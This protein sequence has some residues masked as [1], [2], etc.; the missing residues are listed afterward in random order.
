MSEFTEILEMLNQLYLE[1]QPKKLRELT[2]ELKEI[3]QAK[4]EEKDIKINACLELVEEFED[5]IDINSEVR[6]KIW[7]LVSKLEELNV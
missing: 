1:G 7:S 4:G 3:L 6:T 5:S 2:L